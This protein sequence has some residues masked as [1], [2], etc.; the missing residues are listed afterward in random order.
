MKQ[1][2]LRGELDWSLNR[3]GLLCFSYKASVGPPLILQTSILRTIELSMSLTKLIYVLIFF[4]CWLI[5][6]HWKNYTRLFASNLHINQILVDNSNGKMDL[7]E[8]RGRT[9]KIYLARYFSS[10]PLLLSCVCSVLKSKM[11]NELGWL[12]GENRNC[13]SSFMMCSC[14]AGR[15]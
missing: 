14:W 10:P 7:R 12:F 6:L 4:N 11:Q 9:R 5:T 3:G 8:L 15:S 2:N 1:M 13:L